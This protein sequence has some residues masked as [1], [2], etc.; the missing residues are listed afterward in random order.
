[1]LLA[2]TTPLLAKEAIVVNPG[3]YEWSSDKA[4]NWEKEKAVDR[5]KRKIASNQEITDDLMSKELKVFRERYLAVKS[6]EELEKLLVELDSHYESYPQD[7]KFFAAL[8]VPMHAL[9]GFTYKMY[10]LI[11]KEKLSHS[12]VLSSVLNFASMM[13]INL[14]SDQWMA[15]FRYTSEPM[16]VEDDENRFYTTN[17]VQ[18]F[19]GKVMYPE[20]LKAA[21]RIKALNFSDNR[22]V[23]DNKLLYGTAS[24]QDGFRR[25][26]TIGEA[27][28]LATLSSIHLGLAAAAR[29]QAYNIAELMAYSKEIASLYGYDSV[30]SEVDGVTASKMK[31]V[32]SK[33][34]YKN[35]FTLRANGVENMR[36]AFKHLKEGSRLAVVAWQELKDR[37]V[38]ES[39]L[40]NPNYF[41]GF[42][43]RIDRGAENVEKML[44]GKTL[45]R[46]DI[47]GEVVAVDFPSFYTNPPNDLKALAPVT[48]EGGEKH[49]SKKVTGADGKS[50]TLKYRN[51]FYGRSMV[52]DLKAYSRIFPELKKGED[53]SKAVRIINQ[54]NGA[55]HAADH[56]NVFMMY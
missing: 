47:T 7:L 18:D 40:F 5:A 36:T 41:D 4:F 13:K 17:D 16:T 49:F 46:S 12:V 21:L 51:Y 3:N 20:M 55:F 43:N 8:V 44:S 38:S 52:W 35:L 6:P 34:K 25:Y 56:F 42:F 33:S 14:P 9:R 23:W 50:K 24:F 11:T 37:S 54:S 10:P 22:I 29:F 53:V 39:D 30:F 27:E 31:S 32:L 26:N 1:M 19:F 2:N 45:V 15:G 28:R 48:F